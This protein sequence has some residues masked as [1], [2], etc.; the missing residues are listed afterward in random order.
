MYEHRRPSTPANRRPR[1]RG[2]N[3]Q[4]STQFRLGDSVLPSPVRRTLGHIC[5]L[6]L[7]FL[8]PMHRTR[9]NRISDKSYR[10]VRWAKLRPSYLRTALCGGPLNGLVHAALPGVR[11]SSSSLASCSMR[12][13]LPRRGA[14]VAL[15][16]CT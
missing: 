16:H 9:A 1:R 5:R 3:Q 15:N 8:R 10:G 11:S 7:T 6:T 13:R 4:P 14:T 2:G 12:Q